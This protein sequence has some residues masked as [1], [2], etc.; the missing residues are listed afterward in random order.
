MQGHSVGRGDLC[1]AALTCCSVPRGAG[2]G[3]GCYCHGSPELCGSTAAGLSPHT[4]IPKSAVA[5][6][7]KTLKFCHIP[8]GQL[9]Q[10]FT[11]CW[12]SVRSGALL[13]AQDQKLSTSSLVR[14]QGKERSPTRHTNSQGCSGL[15]Q[16][17]VSLA[18][19]VS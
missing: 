9:L 11:A 19:A 13:R 4:A 17:L 7:F 10:S 18:L 14:L 5:I 16:L 1:C 15:Q 12:L 8:Q 2:I 3:L 6:F